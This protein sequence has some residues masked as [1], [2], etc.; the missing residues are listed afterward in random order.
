MAT[1]SNIK[2]LRNLAKLTLEQ[3]SDK[4]GVDVGTISALENRDSQRS[5]YFQAIARAFG[6]ST[7]ELA[8]E[9][10]DM[11]IE[12]ARDLFGQMK[13]DDILHW[14]PAEE[15]AQ[16]LFDNPNG[17]RLAPQKTLDVAPGHE[18]YPIRR[19]LF[20][21]SA[22]VSGYEIEYENGESEPIF[23]GK[24]WFDKNHYSPDKLIAVRISGRS[25]EPSLYDG[26]LVVINMDDVRLQD[27]EVFAANYD[28]ELVIKR[29]KRDAGN[30]YLASD[31]QDKIRF[32]DKICSDGCG[33]IGRIVYK[34]SEHI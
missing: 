12:R 34:Q 15:F 21:L 10:T 29:L 30:W 4:S 5:I 6:I 20:K 31:N 9:I 18:R 8:S 27:G 19:A 7:D 14:P 28:G 33:L 16:L 13:G 25:M 2:K 24:R 3:L 17:P 32:G 1:G 26:D 22:G 11:Q 23:M